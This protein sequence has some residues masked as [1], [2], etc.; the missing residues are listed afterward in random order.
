MAALPVGVLDAQDELP[1]VA[2]SEGAVEEG[3]IGRAD[4]GIARGTGSNPGPDRH[5]ETPPPG[6]AKGASRKTGRISRRPTPRPERAPLIP[7]GAAAWLLSE[8]PGPCEP[9]EARRLAAR[10]VGAAAP[11][12][13]CRG[14]FL[15]A[16][17]NGHAS[18]S[19]SLPS[20]PS[21][22]PPGSVE[23]LGYEK[24]GQ[25]TPGGNCPWPLAL[26]SFTPILNSALPR[27]SRQ[28]SAT[29]SAG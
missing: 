6:P 19:D 29:S 8:A 25:P 17:I 26:G 4:M 28:S 20:S 10:G 5:R 11:F 1:A 24:R 21:A 14:A 3:H 12:D 9:A 16:A 7:A 27:H 2:P 23:S 15:R 18:L 22:P 13:T